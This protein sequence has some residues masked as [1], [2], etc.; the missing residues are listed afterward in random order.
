M[1]LEQGERVVEIVG[2]EPYEYYPLGEYIVSAVG[3]C[4]GEPTF[5]YTRIGIQHALGLLS[6]GRTVHEVAQGYRIPVEAV[7]EAIHLAIGAIE[8]QYR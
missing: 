5:K 3:V 2:G 8:S 4:D 1:A 6:A 7:R